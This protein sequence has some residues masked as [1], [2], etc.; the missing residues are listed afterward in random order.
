MTAAVILGFVNAALSLAAQLYSL[1]KQIAGKEP[2][3]TWQEIVDKN[4]ATQAKIDAEK[5][6]LG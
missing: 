3:P 2:I 5:A 6:R 1:A 4:F